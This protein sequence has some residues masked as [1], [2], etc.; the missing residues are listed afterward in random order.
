MPTLKLLKKGEYRGPGRKYI[1]STEN[2]ERKR[3]ERQSVYQNRRYKVIR[4]LKRKNNP[5]CEICELT[6]KT[7][8]C[9]EVHHWISPFNQTTKELKDYYAYNYDNLVSLCSKCHHRLH[10]SDLKYCHSLEE[11]K[12][13]LNDSE[14]IE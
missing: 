6:G 11:V 5:I 10:D 7:S 12:I 1:N 9:E 14:N 3:R 4:D 8:P 13:K 2:E